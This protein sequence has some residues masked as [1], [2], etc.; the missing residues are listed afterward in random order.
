MIE[1]LGGCLQRDRG[2]YMFREDYGV[3]AMITMIALAVTLCAQAALIAIG[4]MLEQQRP[5]RK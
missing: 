1:A 3:A 2:V 4:F 5:A